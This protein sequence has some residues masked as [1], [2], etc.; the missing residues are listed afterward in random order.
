MIPPIYH[1]CSLS[2]VMS[3]VYFV[4]VSSPTWLLLKLSSSQL[5][6]SCT[7]MFHIA[8]SSFS[9][10]RYGLVKFLLV[11][12]HDRSAAIMLHTY[13]IP[14]S[15]ELIP[16]YRRLMTM[17]HHDHRCRL[18]HQSRPNPH[19]HGYRTTVYCQEVDLFLHRFTILP[20]PPPEPPPSH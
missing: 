8:R 18:L 1:L 20:S 10:T 9:Q 2:Q 12:L 3:T 5:S 15:S 4:P 16:F 17:D 7:L 6:F 14:A 11:P 13:H 19:N